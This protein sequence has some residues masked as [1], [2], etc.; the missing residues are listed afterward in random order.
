MNNN[1]K[2]TFQLFASVGSIIVALLCMGYAIYLITASGYNALVNACRIVVVLLSVASLVVSVMALK[3]P[4]EKA[5][6]NFCVSGLMLNGIICLVFAVGKSLISLIPL[7]PMIL[8]V[9]SLCLK[10]NDKKEEITV[11]QSNN[12]TS[13]NQ[14][15]GLDRIEK[16][17][18][19]NKQGILTDAEM[20]ALII[21]ILKKNQ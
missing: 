21:E 6:M 11:S 7:I 4:S 5:Y 8:F 10:N 2:R 13:N 17:K 16:I 19:L 20:K 12:K 1:L 14:S 18:E 3:N 15:E 9:V